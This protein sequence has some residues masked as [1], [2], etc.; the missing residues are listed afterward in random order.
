MDLNL[1]Y[2]L[3]PVKLTRNLWSWVDGLALNTVV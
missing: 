2:L 1:I 3:A